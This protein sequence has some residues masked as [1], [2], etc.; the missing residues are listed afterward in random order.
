MPKLAHVYEDMNKE[1]QH[2]K[3][4]SHNTIVMHIFQ[5]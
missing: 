1:I 2:E 4:R 5:M 3:D